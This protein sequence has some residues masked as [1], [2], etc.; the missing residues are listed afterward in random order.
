[1]TLE[2]ASTP[3]IWG[4]YHDPPLWVGERPE[5]LYREV[6]RPEA[7]HAMRDEIVRRT[8][9][10]QIEFRATREGLFA[11][12]FTDW[13]PGLQPREQTP[14]FGVHRI[15]VILNRTLVM[16]AFLALLYTEQLRRPEPQPDRMLVTPEQLL[17]F[18]TIEQPPVFFGNVNIARLAMSRG[19]STYASGEPSIGDFRMLARY[20][21]LSRE[22]IEAA[23]SALERFV[24]P[25]DTEELLLADLFLRATKACQDHNYSVALI[26]NWAVAEKLLNELWLSYL[27]ANGERN[28]QPFIS[29]ARTDRL[30]DNRTFTAAVIIEELS[31]ADEIDLSLYSD[32]TVVRQARNKWL[33]SA[34]HFIDTNEAW[35][36]S[37]V[38]QKLFARVRHIDL[39]SP[40]VFGFDG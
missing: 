19:P 35:L 32:L 18:L 26:T 28:G 25:D 4:F 13:P 17:S 16:N 20:Y 10:G 2:A 12:D 14:G 33:H 1:M 6:V 11:F 39:Q 34:T 40:R 37:E 21:T 30:L 24:L 36:S 23:A 3:N 5:E 22:V 29:G 7:F 9:A 8:I 38:C 27:R 15:E 31:L